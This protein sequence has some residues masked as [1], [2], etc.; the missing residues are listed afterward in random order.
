MWATQRSE[1]G[2]AHNG[3]PFTE[4]GSV[5]RPAQGRRRGWSLESLAGPM[6]ANHLPEQRTPHV[7]RSPEAPSRNRRPIV[8]PNSAQP[9]RG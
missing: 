1:R 4:R 8:G 3:R 9:H 7:Q 2:A 6:V 5:K